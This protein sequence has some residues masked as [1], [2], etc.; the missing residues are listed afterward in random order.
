MGVYN[1]L[2]SLQLH[3]NVPKRWL[4]VPPTWFTPLERTRLQPH[5]SIRNEHFFHLS[6]INSRYS[7][8]VEVVK[9]TQ[10]PFQCDIKIY[11]R[12]ELV[13]SEALLPYF[14]ER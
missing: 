8:G 9:H 3:K 4:G 14:L 7:N 11:L 5:L 13:T 1:Y 12:I 6:A 10:L 2:S